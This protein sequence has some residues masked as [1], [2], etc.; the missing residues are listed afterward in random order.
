MV[1]YLVH[2]FPRNGAAVGI[3]VLWIM[4]SKRIYL[5]YPLFQSFQNRN[6]GPTS[7][8]GS[9]GEISDVYLFM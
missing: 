8:Q 2:I 7:I 9:N 5:F 3:G 6:M 4:G 1:T